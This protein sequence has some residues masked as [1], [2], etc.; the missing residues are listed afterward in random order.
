VTLERAVGAV[1]GAARL[2][3]GT[4]ST[5]PSPA[6]LPEGPIGALSVVLGPEVVA[7]GA[8]VGKEAA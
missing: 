8:A 6:L 3:T 7:W 2:F 1:T 4:P 5:T